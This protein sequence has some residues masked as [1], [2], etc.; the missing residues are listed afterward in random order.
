MTRFGAGILVLL[1]R[2]KKE[3]RSTT[4]HLSKEKEKRKLG[5][6]V[7]CAQ[8]PSAYLPMSLTNSVTRRRNKK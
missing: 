6:A 2:D 3:K 5:F 4:F 1:A 7:K 8:P